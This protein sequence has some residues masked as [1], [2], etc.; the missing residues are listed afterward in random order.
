MFFDY[1]KHVL[2]TVTGM[3]Q[4]CYSE[5]WDQKLTDLLDNVDRWSGIEI[6]SGG[7]CLVFTFNGNNYRVWIANRWYAYGNLV[8]INDDFVDDDY[9]YRPRFR[10]MRRLHSLASRM[11]AVRKAAE[12]IRNQR[13]YQ[14]TGND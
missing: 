5:A 13:F 7:H 4:H 10:T 6:S 12:R 11:Q 1:L 8:S 9:R 3:Y 14:E 2:N